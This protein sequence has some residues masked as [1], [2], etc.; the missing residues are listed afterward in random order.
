ML[1]TNVPA[2]SSYGKLAVAH[3]YPLHWGK[4]FLFL[5]PYASY[6]GF[7]PVPSSYRFCCHFHHGLRLLF[8]RETEKIEPGRAGQW[9]LFLPKLALWESFLRLFLGL[10]CEHLVEFLEET[11][12][13]DLIPPK[14]AAS[15]LHS[16]LQA[17]TWPSET[18]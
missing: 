3:I 15:E 2:S 1:F 13:E 9:L 12:Q 8:L 10:P 17:L 18:H 11:L 7:P 5:F 14:S 6:S 4:A 16:L